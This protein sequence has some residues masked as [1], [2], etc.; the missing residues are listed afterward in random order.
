M[1]SLI[2]H[3][4]ALENRY[5]VTTPDNVEFHYRIAGIGTRALGYLIDFAIR[6]AA[7]LLLAIPIALLLPGASLAEILEPFVPRTPEGGALLPA[8]GGMYATVA[9]AFVLWILHTLYFVLFEYFWNGQTP[10]KRLLN[11]RVVREGGY[12]VDFSTVVLRNVFRVVDSLPPIAFRVPGSGLW[13]AFF[14]RMVGTLSMFTSRLERRIGD[15]VAG[16]VVV[17]ER[18]PTLRADGVRSPERGAP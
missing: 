11:I 15:I 3:G 14:T 1:Q 4:A 7:I 9:V 5:S 8:A 12:P 17:F 6:W 10:G 13:F 2:G 18:V 16:T